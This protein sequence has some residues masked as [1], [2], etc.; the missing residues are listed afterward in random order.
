MTGFIQLSMLCT[1]KRIRNQ[2]KE[3]T[4]MFQWSFNKPDGETRNSA[5][6]GDKLVALN[7][8]NCVYRVIM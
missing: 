1:V 7:W 2:S 8:V 3:N 4:R 5:I 6:K